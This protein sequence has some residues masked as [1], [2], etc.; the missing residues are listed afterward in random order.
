MALVIFPDAETNLQINVR[1]RQ[2]PLCPRSS[3]ERGK[4]WAGGA[5]GLR[6]PCARP[7][8]WLP[9]PGVPP[10]AGQYGRWEPACPGPRGCADPPSLPGQGRETAPP[11][12]QKSS[13]RRYYVT[14]RTLSVSAALPLFPCLVCGGR[15]AGC[16]PHTGNLQATDTDAH[17]SIGGNNQGPVVSGRTG[18]EGLPRRL[19]GPARWLPPPS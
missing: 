15:G 8:V 13:R 16:R 11:P 9:P 6:P 5:L 4:Q 12:S 17:G 18:A 1:T 3:W 7:A 14:R 10:G 19:H 2:R